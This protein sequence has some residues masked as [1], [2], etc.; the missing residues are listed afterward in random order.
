MNNVFRNLNHEPFIPNLKLYD[1]KKSTTFSVE[2]VWIFFRA[3]NGQNSPQL[4]YENTHVA[5]TCPRQSRDTLRFP[6]LVGANFD[7][8][9]LAN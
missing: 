8:F 6:R 9:S 3:T 5:L 4:R 7:S 2:C 1:S